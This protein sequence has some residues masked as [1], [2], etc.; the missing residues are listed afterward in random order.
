[1]VG[2][3]Y[4]FLHDLLRMKSV[5]TNATGRIMKQVELDKVLW[6]DGRN[7]GTLKGQISVEYEPFIQQLFAGVMTELG[8]KK[9][10]P[11]VMGTGKKAER[12]V[13]YLQLAE[14]LNKLNQMN[15]DY[16]MHSFG[17][18]GNELDYEAFK[19]KD[20]ADMIRK[21]LIK[22]EKKSSISFVYS[23]TEQLLEMQ[24]MFLDIADA[25]WLKFDGMQGEIE[26]SYCQ[27]FEALLKRGELDLT[28][29]GLEQDTS[30]HLHETKVN[31]AARFHK[32]MID[33]LSYVFDQLENRAISNAKRNFI[34]FFLAWCYFRIPDFRHE[35]LHVLSEEQG[36]FPYEANNS[37]I[38]T[39]LF[40]WKEDFFD[41]LQQFCP[42]F[43]QQQVGLTAALKKNW[44]NKFRSRG[45]IFFYF[46]K[47]WCSYVKKSI[48]V[49]D[50]EW[51]HIPGYTIIV[52]NFLSQIKNR[53]LAK[54]PDILIE[55]SISLLGNP[56]LLK[57]FFYA[58]LEKTK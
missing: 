7:I 6:H 3:C 2:E 22:S 38:K 33:V 58:V 48:V 47:E 13:E 45:I 50:I 51:E 53:H 17:N 19:V 52:A 54:Y 39:V 28:S 1:M 14:H 55:S 57:T 9:A 37:V 11:L 5:T 24:G 43:Q 10:A 12:S 49:N 25:L 42:R 30:N 27:C 32:L 44:R 35:L 23:S 18:E 41:P 31:L 4:V 8:L 20:T 15:A 26:A 56:K 21:I 34:E 46:V 29:I 36:D 16:R 40:S